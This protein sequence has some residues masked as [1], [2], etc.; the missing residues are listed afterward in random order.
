MLR[1]HGLDVLLSR[2][3]RGSL[4]I[5]GVSAVLFLTQIVTEFPVQVTA[6]QLLEKVHKQ[7][8]VKELS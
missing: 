5:L 2:I 8:G 7:F 1:R 6:G 3:A 4:G